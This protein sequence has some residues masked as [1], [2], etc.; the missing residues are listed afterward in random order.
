[1]EDVVFTI[2]RHV[3]LQASPVF[4]DMFVVGDSSSGEGTSEDSPITLEGYK[5]DDFEALLKVL[6]P[7]WV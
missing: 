2:D 6:Y 5:A 4:K 3:L 1:V 7:T